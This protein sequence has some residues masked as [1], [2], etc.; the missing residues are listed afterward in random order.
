M[1]SGVVTVWFPRSTVS[2]YPGSE[3]VFHHRQDLVGLQHHRQ[4]A[5]LEAVVVEDVGKARRDDATEALIQQRPG[6]MFTRRSAAE[7]VARQE[8]RG[9]LVAGLVQKERR[10]LA[11]RPFASANRRTT[12]RVSP[13]RL[14]VFKNCFG[15]I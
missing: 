8:D 11:S 1:P 6:G 13:V 10:I 2:W 4:N 7:V 5:V 3:D 14:I 9:P 12:L 15:M